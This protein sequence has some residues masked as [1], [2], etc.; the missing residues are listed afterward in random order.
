MKYGQII[1][2]EN[3]FLI[4]ENLFKLKKEEHSKTAKNHILKLLYE[5]KNA[6]I[7]P[8]SE[9]PKD[10]IRLNS[11][12]QISSKDNLWTKIF[13]LVL[14]HQSNVAENK[15]SL[16]LPMGTAVLGYAKGDDI[17]WEF[18]S[19]L[20]ELKVIDVQQFLKVLK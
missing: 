12:V 6:V 13:E 5:L 3:E 18:P 4:L 19:G 10:V 20:K 15:I 14:P 1:I 9:M 16:L 8:E 11:Q 2:E 17:L 7:L